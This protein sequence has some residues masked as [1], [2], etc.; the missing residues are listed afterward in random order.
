MM[1]DKKSLNYSDPVEIAKGIHWVGFSDKQAGLQCNPYLVHDG[2]EAV[3]IDGG[4]R[5]HFS[6]VM[7]KILQTGLKP[8]MI[9][10]L[11]YQHYDPD[12]CGSIPNFEEMIG[13][14]NLKI[15]SHRE[16][17]I[18]IHYYAA[19]A[20]RLCIDEIGNEFVFSSG[21][22]LQFI[23]TPYAHSAGSFV[24]FDE[25]TRTLFSSDLFGSVGTGWDLF[26]ELPSG[27]D[28]CTSYDD[29]PYGLSRCPMEGIYSFHMR[30]MTSGKAL[31][32][33]MKTVQNIAPSVVAPQHGSV[34]RVRANI[35][36]ITEGLLH[37]Q[38]V[39]I[40]AYAG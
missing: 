37:L 22:R 27:C 2:D 28:S 40:D 34:I 20:T 5:P 23:R 6:T 1:G 12:L 33:A 32:L 7:M 18:F 24:T 10:R 21:R 11:I 4:S 36:L 3:L 29:C 30:I 16:N 8:A 25:Q 31:R 19:I 9:K 14:G 38:K 17:N 15:I 39:G 13:S 26:M 35:E